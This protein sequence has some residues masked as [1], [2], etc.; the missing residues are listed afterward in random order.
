MPGSYDVI[1]VHVNGYQ[2]E[3]SIAFDRNLRPSRRLSAARRH[4]HPVKMR[5]NL[6]IRPRRQVARVV[7]EGARAAHGAVDNG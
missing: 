3:G 1:V 6:E 4:L 2:K 7:I 5:P